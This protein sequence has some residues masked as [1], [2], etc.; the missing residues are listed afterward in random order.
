MICL[1]SRVVHRPSPAAPSDGKPAS[2][3]RRLQ[4]APAAC[5]V[6]HRKQRCVRMQA[7]QVRLQAFF[8]SVCSL[9][10]LLRTLLHQQPAGGGHAWHQL[11]IDAGRIIS[12][13]PSLELMSTRR[14]GS[15]D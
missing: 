2:A 15:D 11:K 10:A 3:S 1:G 14:Q 5:T 9:S 8:D 7:Y 6:R 12:N 4:A 13:P